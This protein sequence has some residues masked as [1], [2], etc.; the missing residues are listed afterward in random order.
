MGLIMQFSTTMRTGP[1]PEAEELA[2]YEHIS[3]GLAREIVD[4]AKDSQKFRQDQGRKSLSGAIW[5]DRIGQ[6]FAFLTVIVVAAVAVYLIH[7]GAYASA[8]T[9]LCTVL[10][11]GVGVF[12]VGRVDKPQ[13]DNNS[14]KKP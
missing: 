10:A 7:E 12:I 6:I 14:K 11:T 13:N 5:K 4:M 3:K 8:T 9:L 2:K 1:L